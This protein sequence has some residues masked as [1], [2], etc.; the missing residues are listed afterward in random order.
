MNSAKNQT[1]NKQT[2]RKLEAEKQKDIQIFLQEKRILE[3]EINNKRKALFSLYNDLIVFSKKSQLIPN[4][5]EKLEKIKTSEEIQEFIKD[6]ELE[7]NSSAKSFEDY[8]LIQAQKSIAKLNVPLNEFDFESTIS[9][10]EQITQEISRFSLKNI[11]N[12]DII[13]ELAV[14]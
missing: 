4:Q 8:R 2:F 1:L 10:I 6:H 13:R 7:L 11:S 9:Q 14:Y 12:K 3:N 5:L